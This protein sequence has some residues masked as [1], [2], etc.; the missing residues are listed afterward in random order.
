[1]ARVGDY[2]P[3]LDNVASGMCTGSH[4]NASVLRTAIGSVLG[5][6][7]RIYADL[8]CNVKRW[9]PPKTEQSRVL[10][11]R[12]VAGMPSNSSIGCASW[13]EPMECD[14]VSKLKLTVSIVREP[15]AEMRPQLR[16]IREVCVPSDSDGRDRS[17]WSFPACTA[18]SQ[19]SDSLPL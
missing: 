18:R 12:D 11:S 19:L 13:P 10:G 3:P 1:M 9:P 17:F 7:S 6:H 14:G 15:Q 5:R 4:Y 16:P 8:G 2:G